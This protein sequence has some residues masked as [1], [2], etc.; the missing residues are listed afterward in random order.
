[1]DWERLHRLADIIAILTLPT[2]ITGASILELARRMPR[3]RKVVGWSLIAAAVAFYAIDIS[4]R[5]NVFAAPA[6]VDVAIN[7]G[8]GPTSFW[9][10]ANEKP[11]TDYKDKY[12]LILI[13]FVPVPH[14]DRMTNTNI[15]KSNLYTITGGPDEILAA[16]LIDK[17]GEGLPAGN[18]LVMLSFAIVP[19]GFSSEQISTLGDI[20]KIG[21][22]FVGSRGV[23]ALTR[24]PVQS[25]PSKP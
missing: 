12:K 10:T 24:V 19:N 5:F 3:F 6:P 13:A 16:P 7:W 15:S 25:E 8:A 9:M 20:E 23:N 2:A 21:G 14:I 18:Y 17:L 22:K 11:L 4:D 1:M